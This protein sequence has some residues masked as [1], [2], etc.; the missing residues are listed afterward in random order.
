MSL[1][2]LVFLATI[3]VAGITSDFL[4]QNLLSLSL[5]MFFAITIIVAGKKCVFCDEK[6]CFSRIIN[7]AA[8]TNTIN[9]FFV[10]DINYCYIIFTS[11]IKIVGIYYIFQK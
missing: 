4:Q 8:I 1:T 6:N 7:V 3:N 9:V 5:L 10:N 2:K 11:A